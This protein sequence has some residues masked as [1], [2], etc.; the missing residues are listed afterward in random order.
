MATSSIRWMRNELD[1]AADQ[2]VE[3]AERHGTAGSSSGSCLVK[4]WIGLLDPSGRGDRTRALLAGHR[5]E[6][7]PALPPSDLREGREVPPDHEEVLGQAG[8]QESQA[9]PA[10]ARSL[11]RLLQ[12]GATAPGHRTQDTSGVYNARDKALPS[13]SFVKVGERRLRFDRVDKAGRITLRH[14]GRLHHI[15]IGN[16]YAGWR[17]AMLIDGLDVEIV[18]FDAHRCAGWSSTRPRT[19]SASP[20]QQQRPRS[21]LSQTSVLDVLRHHNRRGG[22]GNRTRVLQSLS[23]PSPSA[24][25][26]RLSGAALLPA[27]EPPRNQARCPQRSVGVKR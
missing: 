24:A 14:R 18:G 26:T 27:A 11:R 4:P 2:A 9:T 22:G 6:A 17:V 1:D 12:R 23:R 15:G 21:T 5:G 3:E 7:R 8:H 19:I 10:P 25:G 16:A 20:E 13:P